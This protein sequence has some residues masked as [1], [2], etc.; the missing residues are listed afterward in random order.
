MKFVLSIAIVAAMSLAAFSQT[1]YNKAE[2]FIGFS[3]GQVDGSTFQF[4]HLTEEIGQTGPHRFNGFNAAGVYNL[5]RYVGIRG[6]FSATFNS[7]TFRRTINTTTQLNGDAKNS[8]YNGLVGVQFKDNSTDRRV[9]PFAYLRGGV[10]RAVTDVTSTC[11]GACTPNVF[12]LGPATRRENG[13]AGA[14][15][16]GIDIKL[17]DR[18]DLRAGQIDYNP[19][20]LD[21]GM[22]HNFRL[23]IGIVIK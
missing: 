10:A 13:F 20:N 1:D 15:G 17:N 19:V 8:L 4:T 9:K 23:G 18:F 2:G 11:T 7:G 5:G 14:F 22:L 3:H 21:A 6:D 16:G 12:G